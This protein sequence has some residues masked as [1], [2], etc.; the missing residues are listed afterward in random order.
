MRPW[1][2]EEIAAGARVLALGGSRYVHRLG[3][4]LYRHR[5][6]GRIPLEA[7]KRGP[8]SSP[9][10][11]AARPWPLPLFAVAPAHR[12]PGRKGPHREGDRQTP[13]ARP[14]DNL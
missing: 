4:S 5:S 6:Q 9:P 2:E 1:P 14:I 13:R 8:V 3:M 11:E 7:G 12:R 10:W